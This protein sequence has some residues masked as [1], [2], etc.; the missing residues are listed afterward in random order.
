VSLMIE[1]WLSQENSISACSTITVRAQPLLSKV[2]GH[3]CIVVSQACT[4]KRDLIS[5][6]GRCSSGEGTHNSPTGVWRRRMTI[7]C[8]RLSAKQTPIY[9]I[10]Q[11]SSLPK[12][13][14]KSSSPKQN[15]KSSSLEQPSKVFFAEATTKGKVQEI[16]GYGTAN[17]SSTLQIHYWHRRPFDPEI[18]F[19]FTDGSII[20]Q[21]HRESALLGPTIT[22]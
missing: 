15:Q 17:A 13:N 10:Y 3:Y 18:A 11:K 14:Q 6:I 2:P 22:K 16:V 12:Q 21:S 1:I 7:P 19:C 8:T 20:N 9:V 5:Y 4:T